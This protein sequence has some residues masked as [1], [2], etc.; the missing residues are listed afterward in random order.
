M[1]SEQASSLVVAESEITVLGAFMVA[2][3]EDREA[4]DRVVSSLDTAMFTGPEQQTLWRTLSALHV[5]ND[6]TDIVTLEVALQDSGDLDAIGGL[7]YLADLFDKVVTAATVEYH[8]K[9]VRDRA[10]RRKVVGLAHQLQQSAKDTRADLGEVRAACLA[11]LEEVSLNGSGPPGRP[12]AEILNDPNVEE[13]PESIALPIAWRRRL[14]LISA[15]E[16]G[17]TTVVGAAAA[18]V[19]RGSR[20]LGYPIQAGT[21][22]WWA[23]ATESTPA[24]VVH[25]VKSFG[26]DLSRL[27]LVE[28]PGEPFALLERA[29][30]AWRPDVLVVDSLAALVSGLELE[31]GDAAGW[32]RAMMRLRSLALRYNCAVVAIHHGRKEDG[33]YRDSTA[34]GASADVL[35]ARSC[36]G[37]AQAQVRGPLAYPEH[38]RPAYPTRTRSR[39][40]R[41]DRRGSLH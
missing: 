39:P 32:T 23:G 21:V 26:G 9:I 2:K 10:N 20:W 27:F 17:K 38:D 31:S 41:T 24:D 6:P 36:R 5:A 16:H 7:D 19:T 8:A 35:I 25:L 13:A 28:D 12:A 30:E 15:R 33:S 37:R 3:P 1:T 18:A 4:L 11:A 40:V 29:L 14:T 34:I 22:A